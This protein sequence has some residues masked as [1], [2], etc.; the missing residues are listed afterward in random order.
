MT[1]FQFQQDGDSAQPVLLLANSLGATAAMWDAQVSAWSS[2]YRVLRFNYAGHAGHGNSCVPVAYTDGRALAAFLLAELD[3]LEVQNFRVVGVSLGGMI[4]LQLAALAPARVERLVVANSRFFQEPAGKAMW[5]ERIAK[6]HADGVAS[7]IDVTLERWFTEAFQM[8]HAPTMQGIDRMLREVSNEGYG[9]AAAM[10]RDFDA[11]PDLGAIQ[12]P[13]LVVSGAQDAAA[14]AAHLSVL[15]ELLGAPHLKLDPCA[16]L[17]NIECET[18]FTARVS[19][20]LK[21]ART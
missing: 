11:R 4:G 5:N 2:H 1:Q 16:H 14:P 21:Q 13:V 20:F 7:I 17:S 3:R 8:S 19:E 6:V 12:C 18:P 9:A 10:V 15:A